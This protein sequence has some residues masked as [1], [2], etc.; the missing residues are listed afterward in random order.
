MPSGPGNKDHPVLSKYGRL[1]SGCPQVSLAA[2]DLL[3]LIESG[4]RAHAAAA[5]WWWRCP[6]VGSGSEFGPQVPSYDC[7][8]TPRAHSLEFKVPSS[9]DQQQRQRHLQ[10]DAGRPVIYGCASG[11]IFGGNFNQTIW[12]V[13]WTE[14]E[15]R[16]RVSC[17]LPNSL[18]NWFFSLVFSL[19]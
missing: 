5:R 12:F 14:I 6:H 18:L 4:R 9:A 7:L 16:F 3:V 8:P 17:F 19:S 2:R 11:C 13:N 10:H 15:F 1:V